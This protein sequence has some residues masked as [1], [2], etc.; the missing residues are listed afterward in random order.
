[1]INSTRVSPL[2]KVI[3][4]AIGAQAIGAQAVGAVAVGAWLS[5]HSRSVVLPSGVWLSVMLGFVHSKLKL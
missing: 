3:T 2:R 4:A 1:M 5:A